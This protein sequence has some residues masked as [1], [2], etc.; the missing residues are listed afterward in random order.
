[1]SPISRALQGNDS[2]G[3]SVDPNLNVFLADDFAPLRARVAAM[4]DSSAMKVVGQAETTQACIDGILA[5]RP[6][7]VV[8]D[9]HLEDGTGLE[10]LQVV[11]QAAPEV[12]FVVF[13]ANSG[14]AYRKRYLAAG[15]FRFLDKSTESEQLPQAVAAAS[16]SISH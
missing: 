12:A 3:M 4:L 14:P 15:A 1:M 5:T 7:V 8:L 10:V 2:S 11:R 9:V 16:R 6:D 13:S